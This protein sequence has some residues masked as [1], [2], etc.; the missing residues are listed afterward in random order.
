MR[1]LEL[2][3][4]DSTAKRLRD[5]RRLLGLRT[6][7]EVLQNALVILCWMASE[8]QQGRTIVSVDRETGAQK[9]LDLPSLK[10]AAIN[11][12]FNL[13]L[14]Q[15]LDEVRDEFANARKRWRTGSRQQPNAGLPEKVYGS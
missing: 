11:P 12:V 8:K 1:L 14:E 7:R 5:I 13:Q 6:T 9:E 15:K 3:V 2:D 10:H 4:S